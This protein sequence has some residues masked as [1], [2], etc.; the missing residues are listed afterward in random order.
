MRLLPMPWCSCV[1]TIS[2][3]V[4]PLVVAFEQTVALLWLGLSMHGL[5]LDCG[6]TEAPHSPRYRI[7]TL[8]FSIVNSIPLIL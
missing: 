1:R 2:Q 7:F 8:N 5:S 3:F 6:V 4:I